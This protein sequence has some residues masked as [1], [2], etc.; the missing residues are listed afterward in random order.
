MR[1]AACPPRPEPGRNRP[2]DLAFTSP[3]PAMSSLNFRFINLGHQAALETENRCGR[4]PHFLA[5][6][7]N[8]LQVHRIAKGKR[9]SSRLMAVRKL[10][11][12]ERM[13]STRK[14]MARP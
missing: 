2:S 4:R 13:P 1:C 12:F 10:Q 5:S 7:F 14:R 11:G 8:T 9:S 3:D 6:H